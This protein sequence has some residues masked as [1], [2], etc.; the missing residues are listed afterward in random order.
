MA[1]ENEKTKTWNTKTPSMG[2]RPVEFR[3]ANTRAQAVNVAG[4][5]NQWNPK[6]FKLAKDAQGS[7]KGS[8]SLKPG[9][10]EYRFVVDG[11]WTDDPAAKESVLNGLGG[12]NAVL[13]V[14]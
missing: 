9:R 13:N 5:F 7:W 2:G 12:K 14:K 11:R 3:L 4:T 10:Y 6:A 1:F 8:L